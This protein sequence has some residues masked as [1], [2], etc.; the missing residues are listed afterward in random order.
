MKRIKQCIYCSALLV[1]VA[2]SS[3]RQ[4]PF[5]SY[6]LEPVTKTM[7]LAKIQEREN[8]NKY[9]QISRFSAEYAGMQEVSNLKG[10]ARIAQD[11][12]LMLSLS[13]MVG[14]EAFR[15]LLS[16]DS[17]LSLNRLDKVFHSS[18]YQQVKQMIPLPYYLL[19]AL[20]AYRFD[21][22]ADRNFQLSISDGMYH[23]EDTKQRDHYTSVKVDANYLVR[24]LQFKD[25]ENKASVRVSYNSFFEVNHKRFPQDVEVHIQKEGELVVLRI[26]IKKVDFK[27][28]LSFP[29]HVGN[30]YTRTTE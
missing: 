24:A 8:N 3:M 21:F 14:G 28:S 2:C 4:L 5:S 13:P 25:F 20:F 27:S 29:F 12:L 6:S 9:T 19:E 30:M 17:S 23:L 18:G 22:L 26:A 7:L 10:F 11:S 1:L 16:P 15:L